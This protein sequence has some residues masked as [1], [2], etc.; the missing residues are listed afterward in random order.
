MS[1]IIFC[2][3]IEFELKKHQIYIFLYLPLKLDYLK[4]ESIILSLAIIDM[5]VCIPKIFAKRPQRI[6]IIIN[7]MS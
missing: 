3:Y 4:A 5:Y 7:F 6:Y 1:I 2:T